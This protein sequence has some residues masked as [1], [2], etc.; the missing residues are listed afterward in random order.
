VADPYLSHPVRRIRDDP[1]ADETATLVVDVAGAETADDPAVEAVADA[2]ADLG[3]VEEQERL[4]LG[5]LRVTVPQK[6]VSAVCAV[7]GIAAVETA[8]VLSRDAGDAGEDV[9]PEG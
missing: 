5:S 8:A 3:G 9:D 6:R 4:R 7:E 1:D 2:V